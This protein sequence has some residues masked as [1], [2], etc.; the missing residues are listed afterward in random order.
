MTTE[1]VIDLTM[2]IHCALEH[3]D[4][5]NAMWFIQHRDACYN[6]LPYAEQQRYLNWAR[7]R[8]ES[9]TGGDAFA[10]PNLLRACDRLG[11]HMEVGAVAQPEVQAEGLTE[12]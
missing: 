10:V 12:A 7:A 1:D 4:H 3:G 8:I 5:E 9:R 11:R 6:G 2:R